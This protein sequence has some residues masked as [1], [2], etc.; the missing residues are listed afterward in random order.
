GGLYL[1]V[2]KAAGINKSWIFRYSRGPRT[3]EMGLG[4]LHTITLAEAREK[5]RHARHLLLDGVDPLEAQRA[6]RA[7]AKLEAAK[8]TTFDQ[9]APAHIASPRAGWRNPVHAAQWE[10]TLREY[11]GPIIGALPIAA[12]DTGLVMKVLQQSVEARRG[13]PAGEFWQAGP[14]TA[15]RLRGRIES[16]LDWAKARGYRNGSEN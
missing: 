4:P 2:T 12:I 10:T 3:R 6:A 7:Q 1:Q 13:E 5:A 9:C 11:A 16:V 15:S 14:E 8:A